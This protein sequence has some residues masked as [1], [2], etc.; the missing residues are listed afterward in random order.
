MVDVYVYINIK[1]KI[2]WKLIVEKKVILSKV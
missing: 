2:G 1:Y